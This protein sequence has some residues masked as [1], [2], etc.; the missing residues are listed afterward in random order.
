MKAESL[1]KEKKN[2]NEIERVIKK[3]R[4]FDFQ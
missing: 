3:L 4:N 1:I 2:W